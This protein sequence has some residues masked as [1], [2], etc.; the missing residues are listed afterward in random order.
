MKN[1]L[2]AIVA[3]VLLSSCAK[4]ITVSAGTGN[5]TIT[6][7]P[8]KSTP[9]TYVLVNDKLLVDNKNVKSVTVTGIEDGENK[10]TYKSESSSYKDL[11]DF[12]KTIKI[13]NGADKTEVLTVPP[14]STGYWIYSGLVGAASVILIWLAF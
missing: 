9:R 4:N 12:E 11:M 8:T 1:L 7:K 14:Y 13:E 3:L 2:I 6:M 5:G 10:V